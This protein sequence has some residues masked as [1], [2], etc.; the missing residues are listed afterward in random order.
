[1]AEGRCSHCACP[2]CATVDGLLFW[3]SADTVKT[4]RGARLERAGTGRR[5]QGTKRL[6]VWSLPTEPRRC[7]IACYSGGLCE[8][9]SLVKPKAAGAQAAKTPFRSFAG[10]WES[11][12]PFP[13]RSE[14]AGASKK[15]ADHKVARIIRRH[16]PSLF[17]VSGS[18]PENRR[19]QLPLLTVSSPNILT[20][21][22]AYV[23]VVAQGEESKEA[24]PKCRTHERV[25]PAPHCGR[26]KSSV[27]VGG[28]VVKTQRGTLVSF[29]ND[30]ARVSDAASGSYSS[31]MRVRRFLNDRWFRR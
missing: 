14:A 20:D 29:E 12:G 26:R 1:V 3:P 10:E 9:P 21:T 31:G 7:L 11:G 30:H 27:E 18:F 17:P 23:S 4:N 28:E 19:T 15:V 5:L 25:E 13:D 2:S 24:G 6:P 16:N 8:R 22:F